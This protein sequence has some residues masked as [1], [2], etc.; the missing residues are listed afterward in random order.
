MKR[1]LFASL[2]ALAFSTQVAFASPHVQDTTLTTQGSTVT[3][4]VRVVGIGNA[5]TL[6]VQAQV[7]AACANGMSLGF[8]LSTTVSTNTGT[9]DVS[10][11]SGL[12]GAAL[13]C[14]SITSAQ[15]VS[16]EVS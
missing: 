8:G 10:L 5:D 15:L 7:A 11:S 12:L 16:V 9:Q 1:A 13:G 6:N 3:V 2:I 14:D 4:T